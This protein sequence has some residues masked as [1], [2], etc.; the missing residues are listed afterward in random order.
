MHAQER[1]LRSR[2]RGALL[3]G[4]VG[5]ALGFP[6]KDNSRPF[7]RSL[8]GRLT[9]AFT[10]H[11]SSFYPLGQ[12]TEDTQTSEAVAEAIVEAGGVDGQAVADR[13]IPLWRD[14]LVVGGSRAC[15]EAMDR[16]VRGRSTWEDAG[17]PVGRV[18]DCSLARAI[19]VGLWDHAH[20]D[21]LAEDV[22]TAVSIT[23]RDPRS[24]ASAAAIAAA[25]GH[26]LCAEDLVLGV[27]LDRV[28]SAAGRFS[29]DLAEAVLDFPRIL[30]QSEGRATEIISRLA[31]RAQGV[32]PI[33]PD[34]GVP[35]SALPMT[36]AAIYYFLRG[37]FE[38]EKS[39]EGALRAGGDVPTL[40]SLVGAMVGSL[41]GEEAVPEPLTS[42][43]L[44]GAATADLAD[45]LFARWMERRGPIRAERQE[46]E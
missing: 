20:P 34:E 38:I 16:L 39:V 27:F 33:P 14:L 19:P 23:H 3:G 15:G 9:A 21:S 35:E 24:L 30:S 10:R 7:L 37:P 6:Y 18:E 25:I 26:N 12:V 4:A 36:L 46:A 45:R 29:G 5:D 40:A 11:S 44:G 31:A 8:S 32:D 41:G 28:A 2:F 13:L 1:K 22:E 43:V 17:H 42:S